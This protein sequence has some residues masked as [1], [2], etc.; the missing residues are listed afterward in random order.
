[1]TLCRTS[2]K[3]V[4]GRLHAGSLKPTTWHCHWGVSHSGASSILSSLSQLALYPV[5]T[6]ELQ[7]G[8]L[9]E[10][11]TISCEKQSSQRILLTAPALRYS[12]HGNL[13]LSLHRESDLV[14]ACE[15]KKSAPG[16]SCW[17]TG[18]WT[19]TKLSLNGSD[20][21]DQTW[22]KA[23][24]GLF[25]LTWSGRMKQ[26]KFLLHYTLNVNPGSLA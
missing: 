7:S 21:I 8:R 6:L 5:F 4:H 9:E 25:P 24:C 17:I 18:T 22:S 16:S 2:H 1:M 13:V 20:S 11:W 12:S 3:H 10:P 26:Y 15:T 14:D 19:L 23:L